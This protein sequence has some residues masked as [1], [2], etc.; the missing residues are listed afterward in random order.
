[1]TSKLVT[2][3]VGTTLEEAERILGKHRIEKLPVVD[4]KGVLRGLITV[5]DIHQ[6]RAFPNANKDEHGRLRVAAAIRA[7]EYIDR[8][9]P[10]GDAGVDVLVVD[11][12][13]GHRGGVLDA[14]AHVR[15][16]LP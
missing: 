12:A 3:P 4:E 6:R 2:A 9:R 13:H 1:M 16:M 7:T 14:T 8:A 15:Q 5:R 11:T 10:L